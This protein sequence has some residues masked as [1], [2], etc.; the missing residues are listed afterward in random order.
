LTGNAQ[1]VEVVKFP[2]TE[3]YLHAPLIIIIGSLRP[4]EI[5]HVYGLRLIVQVPVAELTSSK[6]T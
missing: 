2:F 3:G 5:W 1:T 6:C 4:N